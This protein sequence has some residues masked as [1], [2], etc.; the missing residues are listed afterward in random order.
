MS[1][2][3]QDGTPN[4]VVFYYE[5]MAMFD[6]ISL[7]TMYR[8]RTLLDGK[9]ES[10]I[11]DY[12]MSTDELDAFLVFIRQAVNDAF[13][14][15]L[16]MTTGIDTQ[17]VFIDETIIIEPGA[18]DHP[19]VY[20]FKIVDEEAYN[21]NNLYTVD[22]G[23]KKYLDYHILAAWYEMVGHVEENAKWMAKRN[24]ARTDLITRKLF[25]L[26]KP[27]LS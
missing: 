25:Q 20:G 18:V 9:G 2:S 27:S 6:N 7:R 5:K 3:K 26:K 13:D 10:Q 4:Y 22:D 16:K 8:A 23:I 14:V 21:E 19:N 24:D 1:Y 15:V 17:P 11:D 12:A